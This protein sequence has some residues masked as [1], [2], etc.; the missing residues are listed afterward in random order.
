MLIRGIG[1]GVAVA[2]LQIAKTRGAHVWVTSGSDEKL[3]KA[4]ALGADETLNYPNV[5][6]PARFAPHA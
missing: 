2:A 5:D 1:G 3:A 4:A 6:V